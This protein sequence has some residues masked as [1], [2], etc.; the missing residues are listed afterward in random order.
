MN[1]AMTIANYR[2]KAVEVR[3]IA[4]SI[5]DRECRDDLLR[6]AEDYDRIAAS[7]EARSQSTVSRSRTVH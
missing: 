1:A 7:I 6:L 2:R 4:D 3:T 5:R